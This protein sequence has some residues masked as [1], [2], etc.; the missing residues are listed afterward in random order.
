MPVFLTNNE[1]LKNF[2]YDLI[3]SDKLLQENASKFFKESKDEIGAIKCLY[4]GQRE[5]ATIK[6]IDTQIDIV[7]SDDATTCHIVLIV[8][9]SNQNCSLCHFDGSDMLEGLQ[10]L[11]NSLKSLNETSSTNSSNFD[12][13][14]VGGFID[15]RHI[16]NDVTLNLFKLF[17]NSSENFYL[18]LCI[19]SEQ[20]DIIKNGI[21]YPIAYGFGYNI[22]TK[23]IFMCNKFIDK[24]PDLEVRSAR[25]FS[26]NGNMNIYDSLNSRLVIGPFDYE[27][28][29]QVKLLARLPD[30]VLLK[31]FSTSPDQEPP[32]FINNLKKTFCIMIEHPEP[33]ISYFRNMKSFV[34]C[35]NDNGSWD[36]FE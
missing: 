15:N 6:S 2:D 36:L 34:Y 5:Y 10:S 35:K 25:H 24:G 20:N 29:S 30:S 3:N 18:K 8:D 16:S 27:P 17:I 33:L 22:K 31:Y 4:V 13:Y 1:P 11:I 7:G 21:H 23:N 32:E 9:Q 26:S 14:I 28:I 12:L 19:V